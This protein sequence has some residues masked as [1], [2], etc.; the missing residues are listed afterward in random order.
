MCGLK[1]GGLFFRPS[2]ASRRTLPK[3][4]EDRLNLMRQYRQFQS[5]IRSMQIEKIIDQTLLNSVNISQPDMEV[6]DWADE[7]TAFG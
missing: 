1:A 5:H 4:K 3:H 2:A 6:S 7:N